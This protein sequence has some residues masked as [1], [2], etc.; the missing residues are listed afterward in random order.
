MKTAVLMLSLSTWAGLARAQPD[1]RP[2]AENLDSRRWFQDA[3]LGLFIHWGISTQLEDGEWVMENKGIRAAD[4]E[5]LAT[6]FNPTRFSAEEWVT[7]AKAAGMKY[8]TLITKHHDGFALWDSKA[9]D[10]DV[11]DRTP[12]RK[13]V[14]RQLAE[15]C[16]RHG[17]KLFLYYSQLDWR[18]P[19][20]FPLGQAGHK[21]GREEKGDWPRYLDY[22][23]AQLS[24]LLTGYGPIGGIWFDGMWD[25]PAADWRLARTYALIHRLQP[26]ALVG[27]NHHARPIPGEDFQMFEKDL[28]GANTAGFNTT[29]ISSL[30]LETAQTMNDSWGFR[31]TDRNWKTPRQLIRELVEAAGRNANYLLNVGPMPDGA[32][33]QEALAILAAIGQWTGRH[34]ESIYGTRGGPIGPRPW[35]VTTSKQNRIYLHLLDWS[36]RLLTVPPVDAKVVRAYR[37]LDQTPVGVR[38][39]PSGLVIT[40]PARAAETVDEVIVLETQPPR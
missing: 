36:D 13:D 30:P 19:D 8:L 9:S 31:L 14:V 40:L 38:V 23:D 37:L 34:G 22:L 28:P 16:Q 21:A 26:A 2:A 15:P 24:E 32:F 3:K 1:Y 20:Y 25:K 10:W 6:R 7:A 11:V 12:Y 35:G 27:S 33:P 17:L 29:E 18:H 5:H 4:Y 39:D